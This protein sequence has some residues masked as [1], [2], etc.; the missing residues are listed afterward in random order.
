MAAVSC[1]FRLGFTDSTSLYT[2][3]S[4]NTVQY[5]HNLPRFGIS[6]DLE[7]FLGD[8]SGS[9]DLYIV[10]VFI[11]SI[12][13]SLILIIY[14]L[15]L[16]IRIEKNS[17]ERY[18]PQVENMKF[19]TSSDELNRGF[20]GEESDEVKAI[21]DEIVNE[22]QPQIQRNDPN[23]SL[24]G[25][26]GLYLEDEEEQCGNVEDLF[27]SLEDM[28][29]SS[30]PGRAS[31]A[32]SFLFF[33]DSTD[34]AERVIPKD[35][36]KEIDPGATLPRSHF[37]SRAAS[38]KRLLE[39]YFSSLKNPSTM[40]SW[41]LFGTHYQH[42]REVD[43][44]STFQL[45]KKQ[46]IVEVSRDASE[47]TAD[48][49]NDIDPPQR[50]R[51]E[52]TSGADRPS[53]MTSKIHNSGEI[54]F[55]RITPNRHLESS[56]HNSRYNYTHA[57]LL[58]QR[59]RI[60]TVLAGC[61]LI[62]SS[63]LLI[64]NGVLRL[65]AEAQNTTE[66]WK[67]LKFSAMETKGSVKQFQEHQ[68][69]ILQQTFEVYYLL[70][71]HC[72][73]IRTNICSLKNNTFTCNI[74]GIPLETDWQIWLRHN[75]YPSSIIEFGEAL[76]WTSAQADLQRFEQAPFEE[77]LDAW[78]KALSTALVGC[79]FLSIL[80]FL[81]LWSIAFPDLQFRYQKY[82]ISESPYA[83]PLIYWFLMIAGWVFGIAF[84]VVALVTADACAD[85][86]SSIIATLFFGNETDNQYYSFLPKTYWSYYLAGCPEQMYPYN[87]AQEQI[88]KW[89]D[90]IP[91]TAALSN[92]LK[93][94]SQLSG[95][96]SQLTCNSNTTDDLEQAVAILE[97]QL[98][99][100]T[101][102]FV[103]LR[104]QLSCNR[105]YPHYQSIV[106]ES[107]CSKGCQSLGWASMAQW[108]I[109]IMSVAIWTFRASF[110]ADIM[111]HNTCDHKRRNGATKIRS[112][113][114]FCRWNRQTDKDVL[115]SFS[116]I[117]PYP[118]DKS[119]S[120]HSSDPSSK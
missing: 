76:D 2:Y 101:Q 98:C 5:I 100:A 35:E 85:S 104:L 1:P 41:S 56:I 59:F 63:M 22:E 71:D 18:Q 82:F 86:P 33:N 31:V 23:D 113:S 45:Q 88:S 65:D 38:R 89:G 44:R 69:V 70:S 26:S 50:I 55:A 47:F 84:L 79:I 92:A 4:S 13:L 73:G 29:E 81:I 109:L 14:L 119:S 3:E 51:K 49:D 87:I 105:W 27:S 32:S 58:L 36:L 6:S 106:Y 10:G 117:V 78:R 97:L 60:A 95:T 74:K 9:D 11:W 48:Q 107:V 40:V 96:T 25:S 28:E 67:K 68:S 57:A 52:N 21:M 64:T 116:S 62:I 15:M 61:L 111:A 42:D 66:E 8:G 94:Q 91:P 37:T 83:F 7:T 80:V 30:F 17:S 53:T 20:L 93:V 19:A 75:I 112:Y 108:I 77:A 102:I 12:V 34:S 103:S 120:N 39:S 90:L 72:P 54:K 115:G 16:W 99:E 43:D 114:Y 110:Q 46:S 24:L 118:T